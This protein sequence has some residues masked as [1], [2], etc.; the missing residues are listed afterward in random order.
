[1]VT[2]ITQRCFI[3][4]PN[5]IKIPSAE[6]PEVKTKNLTRL[7]RPIQNLRQVKKRRLFWLKLVSLIRSL[8]MKSRMKNV[9]A[10]HPT[11]INSLKKNQFTAQAKRFPIIKTFVSKT[12]V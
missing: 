2:V 5:F 6:T 1:M 8:R 3:K 4:L 11:V 7:P 9:F 12:G 10:P